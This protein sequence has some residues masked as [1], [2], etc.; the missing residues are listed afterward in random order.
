M[1]N[2]P[3]YRGQFAPM[4]HL[5]ATYTHC[6]DHVLVGC[7]SPPHGTLDYITLMLGVEFDLSNLNF[8]F[9]ILI[10]KG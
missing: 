7:L 1:K 9:P 5:R 2:N 4:Q 8:V 3:K 6:S 10:S